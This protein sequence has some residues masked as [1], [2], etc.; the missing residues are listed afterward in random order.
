MYG[1]FGCIL[2]KVD[3][4]IECSSNSSYTR[5]FQKQIFCSFAYKVVCINNNFSK[6]IVLY[7]GKDTVN[8]FVKSI[9]NEYNYCRKVMKKLIM[10]V[11]KEERFEQSNI[12]WVV[13]N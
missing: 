6:K 3:S 2:K 4:D 8:K 11:E 12:C 9:L 5:K 10:S 7:R 1:D 13:V